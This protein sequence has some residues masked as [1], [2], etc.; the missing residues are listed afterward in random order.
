MSMY[1]FVKFWRTPPVNTREDAELKL[2]EPSFAIRFVY[3][4]G[5][6][7]NK[8][9]TWNDTL[10]IFETGSVSN[11]TG[12][13]RTLFEIVGAQNAWNK[14][15]D[16]VYSLDSKLDVES[17]L[18]LHAILMDGCYDPL[19]TAKGETPGAFKKGFYVVGP[20]ETGCAPEDAR[21]EMVEFLK[22]IQPFWELACRK[23]HNESTVLK[24][25]A[26]SH[27]RFENIHAF[28]DGNG[29]LGRLLLNML[30]M[31][32]AFPPVVFDF[33]LKN[34]YCEALQAFHKHETIRPFLDFL[35]EN[36]E[37]TWRRQT[38]RQ[39]RTFQSFDEDPNANELER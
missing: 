37:R 5:R 19:R 24:V 14:A 29:R 25:A 32:N 39:E 11:F 6:T 15:L 26:W 27:C 17:V 10:E 2:S 20:L 36:L 12:S 34:R 4:S 9:I 35:V 22:E 16:M 8:D 3:H 38:C 28:A 1:D 23:E 33:E 30:L 18:S 21:S 13:I 7:E 31:R